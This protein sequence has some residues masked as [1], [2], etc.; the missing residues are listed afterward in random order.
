M[1]LIAT[2]IANLTDARFFAAYLPELLVLP[3]LKN[4]DLETQL[5]WLEQVK[6][7]IEGP[8]WAIA[9]T[10]ALEELELVAILRAGITTLVHQSVETWVHKSDGFRQLLQVSSDQNL[11]DLQEKEHIDAVIINDSGSISEKDFSAFGSPV[12]LTIST[13]QEY[14]RVIR[15]SSGITGI[16]L[17]GGDEEKVGLKSYED[18]SDLLEAV[19]N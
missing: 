3:L 18:L 1:K 6:P 10:R 16:V 13:L 12:Y 14:R 9:P 11:I 2:N 5:S 8:A 17:S 7:W 4:E 15:S 19:F